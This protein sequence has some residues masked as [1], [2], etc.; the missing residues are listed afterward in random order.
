MSAI[1]DAAIQVS[2]DVSRAA[3]HS[4][5]TYLYNFMQIEDPD[6]PTGL[7]D[8][9]LWPAQADIL[10]EWEN[11][12]INITLKARQLGITQ[13]ALGYSVIK[14][15]TS[16]G[17]TI[18]ALSKKDSDSMELVR[19]IETILT[20]LPS[21]CCCN[22]KKAPPGYPYQ[23]WAVTKHDVVI[24]HPDSSV[25]S[26]FI[27][28]P[29]AQDSGRSFT[30]SLVI[31]DE[32]AFQQW[33]RTIWD[34]AYPTIARPNGGKVI[35]IS[36]AKRGTLFEEF[37]WNGWK[38]KGKSIFNATFIPWKARPDRTNE[39]YEG[40]KEA[41]AKD[42]KYMQ[43]FPAT[44]EEAFSAGEATAFPEFSEDVHVVEPF[45]IPPHW[46]RWMSC[47]NGYTDPFAW[48]W[49]A[50]SEDGQVYVYREY[51]RRREDERVYYTDQGKEVME[52]SKLTTMDEYGNEVQGYE[53]I[54]FIVA[55]LDAWSTHHRDQTSK[56][57]IDYYKE[58]GIKYG[59]VPT[60]ADRKLRKAT[61][62]EYLKAEYDENTNSHL[63][64]VKIFSTCTLLI[65]NIPLLLNDEK[66]SEKVAD[67]PLDNQYDSFGY[68]LQ[69]RHHE[70]SKAA[71]EEEVNP[72]LAHKQRLIKRNAAPRGVLR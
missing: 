3:M 39:W 5:I 72:V 50:V 27:A 26:R 20:S 56:N 46:R 69:F 38:N 37:F 23:T 17:Y 13:T 15:L 48:Y 65:E 63:T 68:G 43:E 6:S 61:V 71:V 11:N 41:L 54:D 29:A 10:R 36:T 19:R 28:M 2:I 57:L 21:W 52:R 31:L 22:V 8:F 16:P 14:M 40:V 47:D 7:V 33:A 64:K 30:A 59:F 1:S 53:K 35:I 25:E 9:G 18:V 4:D 24:T 62:A 12:R 67:G 45:P 51:S 70:M 44:P 66:D 60:V 58:G 42:K 55:G 32:H 34:A 49:Y